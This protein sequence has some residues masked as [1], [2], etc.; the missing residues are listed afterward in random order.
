MYNIYDLYSYKSITFRN[1]FITNI[2]VVILVWTDELRKL[3]WSGIPPQFRPVTW[4][5]LSVSDN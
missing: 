2:I 3:S 1:V 5:I 4:K